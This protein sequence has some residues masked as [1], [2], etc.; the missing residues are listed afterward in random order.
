MY[1]SR[2]KLIFSFELIHL[3]KF[4]S[5]CWQQMALKSC[6]FPCLEN[7]SSSDDCKSKNSPRVSQ[8]CRIDSKVPCLSRIICV[9]SNFLASIDISSKMFDVKGMIVVSQNNF[10]GMGEGNIPT[11]FFEASLICAL[12]AI[13]TG[14]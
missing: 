14:D 12:F 11:M 9:W 2:E 1:G 7:V 13:A 10:V 4:S 6:K 8:T 3:S 5:L